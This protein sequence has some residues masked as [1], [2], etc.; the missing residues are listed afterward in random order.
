LFLT[1]L[2]DKRILYVSGSLGLGHIIRDL[3]I[4]EELRRLDPRLDFHWL[5]AEPARKV[6]EEAGETLLPEASEYSNDNS[7]AESAARGARLNLISYIFRA[8]REWRNN[9]GIFQKVTERGEYDL[10]IGDETYDIAMALN[11]R[12]GLKRAPFVMIY[13]FVGLDAMT[14][15]P[16]ERLGVYIFNLMWAQDYRKRYHPDDLSLFVGTPEDV[17]DRSFGL[18]LPNRREYA[19]ARYKFLG[20]ILPFDIEDYRDPQVIRGELGYGEEPLVICSIGGTSIGIELLELC[21]EACKFI[22][23]EIPRLRMVLVCG[24]RLATDE[25]RVPDGVEVVGY[26]PRLYEHLAAC[27]LSIVQAG[28]TTTLELTALRRPFLYFPI[29]GHFE[30]Q[31]HVAERLRRHGAG[32]KMLYSETTPETLAETV[33]ENLGRQVDYEPILTDGAMKAAKLIHQLL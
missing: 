24:P 27:D 12:P 6:V 22:R 7:I 9:V 4:A 28:A 5:A 16:L 18:L 15:N 2:V 13:D 14:W 17:P 33:V 11:M 26:V 32:V 29:E 25:L 21:G 30:Q 10:V 31:R 23:R 1:P 3:A 19:E 8:T 20:Y